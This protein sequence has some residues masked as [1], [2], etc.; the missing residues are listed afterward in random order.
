MPLN[1]HF[2][3]YFITSDRDAVITGTIITFKASFNILGGG[4][5]APPLKGKSVHLPLMTKPNLAVWKKN[6]CPFY[7]TNEGFQQIR[8]I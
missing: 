1:W 5:F 6:L 7:P 8:F 3:N 2:T 4:A